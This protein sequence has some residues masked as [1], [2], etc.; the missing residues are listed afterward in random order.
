MTQH[1]GRVQTITKL[2]TQQAGE[3]T[4][5][6]LNYKSHVKKY[7]IIFLNSILLQTILTFIFQI[8]GYKTTT[9]KKTYKRTS[10]A[11][12]FVFVIILSLYTLMAIVP[13]GPVI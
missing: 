10:F 7:N 5:V 6:F 4:K 3:E 1:I 13:I 9:A 12:G 8:I 11:F 2:K